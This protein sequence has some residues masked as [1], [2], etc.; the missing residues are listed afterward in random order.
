MN[1]DLDPIG[2]SFLGFPIMISLKGR[3]FGAKVD[4][5]PTN[6]RLK[7]TDRD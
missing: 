5:K 1:D 7:N 3:L 6:L 2:P 4:P